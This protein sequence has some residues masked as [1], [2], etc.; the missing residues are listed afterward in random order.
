LAAAPARPGRRYSLGSERLCAEV[1]WEAQVRFD[2]G[3]ACTVDWYRDN[4]AWWAPIR[5][6]EY[7]DY[8]REALRARARLSPA[9]DQGMP[10]LRRRRAAAVR[11]PEAR[12]QAAT[13]A[14]NP[15]T[16]L[17]S[18]ASLAGNAAFT[19]Y[20][21]SMG[22][23]HRHDV[24]AR[25]KLDLPKAKKKNIAFARL[26]TPN[27]P[28]A[29]GWASKL[30]SVKGA[31]G[32]AEFWKAGRHDDFARTVAALQIDLGVRERDV[33]GV[34][35]PNTWARIAGLGEAMAGIDKTGIESVEHRCYK[36]T[37]KRMRTGHQHAEGEAL[38]APDERT[39]E[40]IMAT[41]TDQMK[42]I[43]APYRAAGAAGALVYAGL[44][45]FVPEADIWAG[46]L[47]PGATLQVFKHKEAADLLRRAGDKEKD[48]T[49]QRLGDA[50]FFYG[51]SYVFVRYDTATNERMLVRHFGR[52]EWVSKGAWAVWIAANTHPPDQR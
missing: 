23:V 25:V 14:T 21:A 22:D 11:Q 44:G 50:A 35:G 24:R 2:N 3:L 38:T 15:A 31:E 51:T 17:Q 1:G 18:L 39:F 47:R 29:L 37:E 20:A 34:L 9:Y 40:R 27:T 26:P 28:S 46:K 6:G 8:L 41:R 10:Q 7:R 19:R 48:K 30:E 42:S 43:E 49:W 36:F 12:A 5:S 13:A 33:D 52:L 45:D 4:E 32:L 16:Q